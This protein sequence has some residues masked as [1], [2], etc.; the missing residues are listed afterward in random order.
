[1]RFLSI[2]VLLGPYPR[3]KDDGTEMKG[4]FSANTA[5]VVARNFKG[6]MRRI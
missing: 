4:P 6:D 2:A 3:V 1:M 5:D